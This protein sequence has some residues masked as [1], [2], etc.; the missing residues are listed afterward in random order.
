MATFSKSLSFM[1]FNFECLLGVF[2]QRIKCM[3]TNLAIYMTEMLS[4]HLHQPGKNRAHKSFN[5]R[6]GLL[7]ISRTHTRNKVDIK[8]ESHI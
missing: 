5:L 8:K 1:F 2:L 6:F 7:F 4:S 3:I